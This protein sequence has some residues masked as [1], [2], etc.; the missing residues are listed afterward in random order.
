M[1]KDSVA[2]DEP[3]SF[4]TIPVF[5]RV[6]LYLLHLVIERA[7][8]SFPCRFHGITIAKARGESETDCPVGGTCLKSCASTRN[9]KNKSS[10]NERRRC[11]IV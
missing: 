6:A 7:V 5:F 8:T 9:G 3:L 2:I 1:S 4:E 11:N 10:V